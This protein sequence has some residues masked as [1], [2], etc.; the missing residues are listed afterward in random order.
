[1]LPQEEPCRRKG[2][3]ILALLALRHGRAVERTWLAGTLWPDASESQ[4]LYDLRRELSRLRRAL[5]PEARRL[6]SP[7]RGD[8]VLDLADADV[9]LCD[10]DEAVRRDDDRALERAAD[11]YRGPLL[12]GCDEAC[13]RRYHLAAAAWSPR[14]RARSASETT[15][16]R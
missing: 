11:L 7:G 15:A 14:A 6:R 5:G 1:M 12:A 2:Q 9:D 10:F 8:L 16:R 13:A 3:W 4:A